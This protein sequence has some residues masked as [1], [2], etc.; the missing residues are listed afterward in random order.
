MLGGGPA[1]QLGSKQGYLLSY[2]RGWAQASNTP[3]REY[4]HWVHEGGVSTPLVVQWPARVPKGGAFRRQPGHLI[5]LMATALDVAGAEYPRSVGGESIRPLEGK[6]L[7]PAFDDE[8]IDR[9]AIYFEHEGNRAVRTTTWKLV[10]KNG[11]PWELYDV[12]A[13]RSESNDLSASR[14]AVRDSLVEKYEAWAKRS[15]VLPGRPERKPDF[16]PPSREYPPMADYE[17]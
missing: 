5:D 17:Q 9:E 2:G 1:W 13:D 14:P 7:V 3:F 12:A 4:K 6:S 8:A 15:Y 11:R 10:A 16:T